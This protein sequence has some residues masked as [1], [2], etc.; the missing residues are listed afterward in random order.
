[1]SKVQTA[2]SCERHAEE[3]ESARIYPAPFRF[4]PASSGLLLVLVLWPTDQSSLFSCI[5]P[6]VSFFSCLFF[7]SFFFDGFSD[8]FIF[9]D[10]F[11]LHLS[12]KTLIL[13]V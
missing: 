11:T 13:G 8:F 5:F 6:F 4:L 12:S 10:V 9:F 2:M 3:L 1:M 7:S